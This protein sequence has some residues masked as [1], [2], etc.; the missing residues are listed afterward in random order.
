M[1][2]YLCLNTNDTPLLVELEVS[3]KNRAKIDFETWARE[4]ELESLF[5][6]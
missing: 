5:I 4:P 2:A 6:V 1:Q 3:L